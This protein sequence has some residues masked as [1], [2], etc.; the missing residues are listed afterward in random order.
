MRR[1]DEEFK[2]EVFRRKAAYC[3]KRRKRIA[4]FSVSILPVFLA[5]VVVFQP[6]AKGAPE[7]NG[8]ICDH[9]GESSVSHSYGSLLPEMIV[10]APMEAPLMDDAESTAAVS[11]Q[12]KVLFTTRDENLSG[13]IRKL[14][15]KFHKGFTEET[16]TTVEIGEGYRIALTD[17]NSTVIYILSGDTLYEEDG[18]V[19]GT[20]RAAAEAL[21]ALLEEME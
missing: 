11:A 5:A 13:Q 7:A 9:A 20:N 10:E 2:A 18:T 19:I 21:L 15:A 6:R 8:M 4:A 14:I 17:E 12:G 16:K 3:R 1:T